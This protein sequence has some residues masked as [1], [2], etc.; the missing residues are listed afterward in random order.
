MRALVI[1]NFS[2][3]ICFT[4]SEHSKI[5]VSLDSSI[6]VDMQRY[7]RVGQTRHYFSL[8]TWIVCESLACPRISRST[9]SET[10]K[11]LGKTRRFFSKYLRREKSWFNKFAIRQRHNDNENYQITTYNAEHWLKAQYSF[12]FVTNGRTDLRR[13]WNSVQNKQVISTRAA[14]VIDLKWRS[15]WDTVLSVQLSIT[16]TH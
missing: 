6:F 1:S 5:Q 3:T 2:K 10:K 11:N 7:Y 13:F 8:F 14:Q 16:H 9:G 4:A 12:I 15:T